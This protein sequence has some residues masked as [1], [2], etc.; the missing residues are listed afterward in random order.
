MGFWRDFGCT[1]EW[2]VVLTGFGSSGDFDMV[3]EEV[4]F[5]ALEF[6]IVLKKIERNNKKLKVSLSEGG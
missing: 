2:F 1:L 6:I 5:G 3:L 4:G